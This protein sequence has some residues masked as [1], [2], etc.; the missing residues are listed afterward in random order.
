MTLDERLPG[1][2]DLTKGAWV[3]VHDE[4]DLDKSWLYVPTYDQR[5]NVESR[6]SSSH[7]NASF[8]YIDL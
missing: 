3:Y 7:L 1:G 8:L 6:S 2:R 5:R 4:I